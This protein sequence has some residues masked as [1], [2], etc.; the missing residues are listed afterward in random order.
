MTPPRMSNTD[1]A[2]LARKY[3][4]RARNY[5]SLAENEHDSVERQELLDVAVAYTEAAEA[6]ELYEE[7]Q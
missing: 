7:S 3:R 2:A 5:E 4:D 6:L 1:A